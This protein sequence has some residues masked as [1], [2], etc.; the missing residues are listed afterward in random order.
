M[1]DEHKHNFVIV[2]KG[3]Y[4]GQLPVHVLYCECGRLK[5]EIIKE[6]IEIEINQLKEVLERVGG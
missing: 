1:C 2:K 3:Y 6:S 4:K 5:M